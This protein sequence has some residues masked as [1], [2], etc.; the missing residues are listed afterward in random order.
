MEVG[1]LADVV[2][3][4][5]AFFGVRPHVV[6]KGGVIA[7]GPKWATP[8]RRSRARNPSCRGRCSVRRRG[9]RGAPSLTFVAPAAIEAGLADHL[10]S[11]IALVAAATRAR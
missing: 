4:D 6:V 2:L 8:T 3:W 5:P 11:A 9:R 10:G 7:S 1:K